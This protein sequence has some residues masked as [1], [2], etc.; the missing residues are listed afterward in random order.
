MLNFVLQSQWKRWDVIGVG[1]L[2]FVAEV[3]PTGLIVQLVQEICVREQEQGVR[4]PF[5]THKPVRDERYPRF[6]KLPS[7]FLSVKWQVAFLSYLH[8]EVLEFPDEASFHYAKIRA[9]LKG[10]GGMIGANDLLINDLLIAAHA[11]SL[12]LKLVMNNTRDFGRAR[13]PAIE[14]WTSRT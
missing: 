13:N 5:W 11:R 14:N 7:E 4:R 1:A 2:A 3:R 10:Q 12:G 8:G 9:E 6:Q